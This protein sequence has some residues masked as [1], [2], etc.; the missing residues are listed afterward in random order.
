MFLIICLSLVCSGRNILSSQQSESE[1]N[2]AEQITT[3]DSSEPQV[4]KLEISLSQSATQMA[5]QEV[6]EDTERTIEDG[7]YEDEDYSDENSTTCIAPDITH[8]PNPLISK[9]A[10][11][12]GAVIIHILLAI[13]MFLGNFFN[14]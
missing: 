11:Q 7:N 13:Y 12:R 3:P 2:S 8:F 5:L 10:R 9:E 4:V 6:P 14:N 1:E